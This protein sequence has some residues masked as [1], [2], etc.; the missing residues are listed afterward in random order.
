MKSFTFAIIAALIWGVVPIIEKLGLS[1]RLEP[2]AGVAYRTVGSAIGAAVLVM[3]LLW[4]GAG[5]T[6]RKIDSRSVLLVMLAGALASVLA[7]V[8]FYA[9]LKTGD[10]SVATPV[11]GSFPLI[12]FVLGVLLLG[13]AITLPKLAGVLMVISGVVL[14][15]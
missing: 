7:Q 10:A 9:A 4:S 14:L 6:L 13:E 2:M 5:E 15:K 12:T 11:A 1:T 3:F 8:F